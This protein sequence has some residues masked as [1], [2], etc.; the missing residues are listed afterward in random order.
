MDLMYY[1]G[2]RETVFAN[3]QAAQRH[4]KDFKTTF[5][6]RQGDGTRIVAMQGKT[7]YNNG[8]PL[9]LGVLSDVTPM[10]ETNPVSAAPDLA[11]KAAGLSN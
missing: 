9:M 3:L 2:D 5:R 6:V 10:A 7:F 4:R 8:S 11:K 1:S